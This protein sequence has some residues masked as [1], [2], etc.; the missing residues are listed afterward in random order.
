MISLRAFP[1]AFRRRVYSMV[2]GSVRIRLVAIRHSALLAWRSPPRLRRCR[3]ICP[4]CPPKRVNLT[5]DP[6]PFPPTCHRPQ[7]LSRIEGPQPLSPDAPLLLSLHQHLQQ[8]LGR[9]AGDRR[10]P[11]RPGDARSVID[12]DASDFEDRD[13]VRVFSRALLVEV[14]PNDRGPSSCHRRRCRL[15]RGQPPTDAVA[16]RTPG[17]CRRVYSVARTRR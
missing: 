16:M 17:T 10:R 14:T 2:R 7:V 8:P 13:A 11:R 3:T 4:E 6:T 5:A 15:A 9:L 1:S 12:I